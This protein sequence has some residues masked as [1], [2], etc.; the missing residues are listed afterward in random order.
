MS[1]RKF[2]NDFSQNLFP[3]RNNNP[4]KL[5][6]LRFNFLWTLLGNVVYATSQWGI[7]ILISKFGSI[8][9]LGKF[10]LALAITAPV[11]MFSNFAL[12]AVQATDTTQRFEFGHYFA[13][14]L[15]TTSSAFLVIICIVF[16]MHYPFDTSL[17][18]L[19]VGAAKSLEAISDVVYGLFQQNEWMNRISISMIVKGI[20]SFISIAIGLL[21]GK[22]LFW[23]LVGMLIAWGGALL[24]YDIPV[25]K[26][27]LMLKTLNDEIKPIW[28]WKKLY[29][30]IYSV[31]P[32]G[33]A[34]SLVSLN[35]NIPRYYL[36]RFLGENDL[37]VF[38]ALAYPLTVGLI[39]INALGQSASP[40]MARYFEKGEI[41]KFKKLLLKLTGFGLILGMAIFLLSLFWGGYLL[42]FM[43][44]PE[45]SRYETEF[46]WLTFAAGIE[47]T[48]SFMGYGMT[49]TRFFKIQ[50]IIYFISI[51]ISVGLGYILIPSYGMLGAAFLLVITNCFR[52]AAMLLVNIIAL[53]QDISFRRL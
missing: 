32:L 26:K 8:N 30:L 33:V 45:F 38:A 7:L 36:E 16:F 18:V 11:I 4:K 44:K 23:G 22:N 19:M 49:A 5:I 43:Y 15:L 31:L 40:R 41:K 50:P 35:L 53:R 10:A 25:A 1:I 48:F 9:L 52:S 46:L 42:A 47:Y 27:L 34:A 20:F 39:I 14:R 17:I 29:R 51:A 6:S 24:F 2:I 28:N 3:W 21:L 12:R 13:L 37:G